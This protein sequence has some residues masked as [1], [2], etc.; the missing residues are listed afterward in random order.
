M[1]LIHPSIRQTLLATQKAGI[2]YNKDDEQEIWQRVF[3]NGILQ[4]PISTT[5]YWVI[6]GL[7]ECIDSGKLFLLLQNLDCSFRLRIFFSSRRLPDLENYVGSL[8]HRVYHHHIRP[9]ETREDIKTFVENNLEELPVHSTRRAALAERLVGMSEGAFLWATLAFTEL[10]G[11]FEEDEINEI[12]NRVPAGMVLLYDRILDSMAKNNRQVELTRAILAWSVCSTRPLSTGELQTLLAY[13]LSSSILNLESTINE[14]CGQLLQITNGRVQIIHP[15]VRQFLLGKGLSSIFG[16]DRAETQEHLALVCRKYLTSDE[17]RPPRH[18]SLISKQTQRL[19][20]VD[21]VSTSL[22][23]HLN[24]STSPSDEVLRVVDTFLTE[25]VLSWIEYIARE[26]QDLRF[27]TKTCESLQRYLDRHNTDNP[28]HKE[29]FNHLRNW[30]EDLRRF[31]LKFGDILLRDPSS[32]Y[33]ILPPLCP[34]NSKIYQDFGNTANGL[35]VSGLTNTFWDDCICSIGNQRSRTLSLASCDGLFAIGSMSGNIR[36]YQQ[37]TYREIQSMHH[38]E[39]VKNLKF[40]TTSQ[41]LASSGHQQ[42]KMWSGTG[43]LLWSIFHGSPLV[44][45]SFAA[46]DERLITANKQSEFITLHVSDG[47]REW[48]DG[49]VQDDKTHPNL[50]QGQIVVRADFCPK[51]ELLAVA[52][53]SGPVEIWSI[54]DDVLISTFHLSRDT[55]GVLPGI[56][57]SHML[58]N[59]NPTIEL[60]AVAYEDGELAIFNTW[61]DTDREIKS[62]AAESLTLAS[63]PDGRTLATGDARGV[64]KIWDFETLT[65]LYRIK[66]TE[67]EVRGLSFSGDGLR[68]YDIR[69]TKTKI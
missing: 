14:L 20:F 34:T 18:P 60:L 58:F 63:T 22:S 48:G 10:T 36:V 25:N 69:D 65:L 15:T 24:F 27:V 4:S 43:E 47:S 37:S 54:W 13:D 52:R 67:Y 46:G 12:L 39:P 44:S 30:R 49:N 28:L 40:S 26:K 3:V 33:F 23:E 66:S 68:L 51:M 6:D 8:P 59:P 55:P 61:S 5:Q 42:L 31:T 7:D 19:L 56:S 45:M 62:Q 38:G 29:N 53:R 2:R 9:E 57:V 11:A 41:L 16:I 21:Y 64:I 50:N 17:M 1:A 35:R 32:V